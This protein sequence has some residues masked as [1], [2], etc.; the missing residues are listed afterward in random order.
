MTGES[1]NN[2]KLFC[3][4][5]GGDATKCVNVNDRILDMQDVGYRTVDGNQYDT[6]EKAGLEKNGVKSFV[7]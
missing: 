2:S 4:R 3:R 1:D 5:L 7:S 6:I